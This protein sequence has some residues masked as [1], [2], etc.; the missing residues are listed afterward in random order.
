MTGALKNHLVPTDM[1]MLVVDF[2]D[3]HFDEVMDYSFTAAVEN[4]LD[5]VADGSRNWV[6]MI[7]KFYT[8]FHGVIEK[9]DD[10]G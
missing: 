1:G 4:Q 10:R 9:N 8:P 6:D 7:S 5:D 3:K 2:L